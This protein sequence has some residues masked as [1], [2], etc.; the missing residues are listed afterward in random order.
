MLCW[1]FQ[2]RLAGSKHLL[3]FSEFTEDVLVISV[4]VGGK[5]NTCNSEFTEGADDYFSEGWRESKRL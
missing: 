5:V 4:K 1:L 3:Y 2:W